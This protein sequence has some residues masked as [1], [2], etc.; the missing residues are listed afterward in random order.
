MIAAPALVTA[1]KTKAQKS[2]CKK[3][4]EECMLARGKKVIIAGVGIFALFV[5]CI[6]ALAADPIVGQWNYTTANH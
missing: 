6:H 4:E 2:Q 3:K 1:N 5:F